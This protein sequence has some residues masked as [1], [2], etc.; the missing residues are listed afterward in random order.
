MNHFN[1]KIFQLALLIWFFCSLSRWI[2]THFCFLQEIV[3]FIV[4][5]VRVFIKTQICWLYLLMDSMFI[6]KG[7]LISYTYIFI[8]RIITQFNIHEA[9]KGCCFLSSSAQIWILLYWYEHWASLVISSKYMNI[10]FNAIIR[11]FFVKVK[12]NI[13]MSIITSE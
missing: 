8:F 2:I 11:L 5:L 4:A 13:S 6:L 7:F 12:D 3:I 9:C 1:N 10:R